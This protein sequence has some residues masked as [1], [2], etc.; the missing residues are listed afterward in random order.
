MS[1]RLRWGLALGLSLL[2]H[3]LLLALGNGWQWSPGLDESP[4]KPLTVELHAQALKPPASPPPPKAAPRPRPPA[5]VTRAAD[6]PPVAEEPAPAGTAA[7]PPAEE[8]PEQDMPAPETAAPPP[9]ERPFAPDPELESR[10]QAE[11]FSRQFPPAARLTY[12]VY[13]GA[14]LAGLAE[15]DW[16]QDNGRYRLD[17][18]LRPV[19]GKRLG[20]LSEGRITAGGLTP[21]RF[22]ARKGGELR[23]QAEFDYQA[24]ILRYGRD[25]PLQETALQAGAQDIVSVA[26]QIALR[27]TA[28]FA[29]PVQITTGKKVYRYPLEAVGES[30]V[31]VGDRE[32]NSVLVK[33]Q[34]RGDT[35]EF[36]LAPD[37]HNLPL[38]IRFR[39]DDKTI[40][41]RLI[42]LVIGADTILEKPP[43]DPYQNGH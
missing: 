38:R 17:V 1:R 37:Y 14:L 28:A 11:A 9:G 30:P 25:L 27:G 15:F 4:L 18:R 26:F 33:S 7:T 10:Q 43:K 22:E 40:D 8:A 34:A 32:I 16:Q 29:E 35:L 13:Y 3:V 42:K 39:D 24:G 12:E 2:V 5:I 19:F 23:E 31:S 36:W 20:Y 41:Q 6:T 21:D